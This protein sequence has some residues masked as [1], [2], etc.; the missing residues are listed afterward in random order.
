MKMKMKIGKKYLQSVIVT[1]LLISS[2]GA[3]AA[4][5]WVSG[6]IDR[7]MTNPVNYGQCIVR[8]TGTNNINC[9][10][11]WYSLGCTGDVV[12]KQVAS[13]NFDIVQM[14]YVMGVPVKLLVDDSVTYNGYCLATGV[15]LGK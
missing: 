12:S 5:E 10:Q 3:S 9:R 13:K 14:A 11:G 1:C 8:T 15:L 4:E 7:L 2:S 6:I